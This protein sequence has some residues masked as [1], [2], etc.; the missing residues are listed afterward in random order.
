E[1]VTL[2]MTLLTAFNVLLYRYSGREDIVV[3][4][5]IAGRIRAEIEGL[6]GFFVNTLALRNDVSGNPT[7]RQLLARVREVCFQAYAHQE[8]PFEK[9]VQELRPERNRNQNPI[10]QVMFISQNAPMEIPKCPGLRVSLLKTDSL[11][12]KFDLTLAMREEKKGQLHGTLQYSTDLFDAAT[13]ERMS[14]HFE[15]LLEGIVADP[16]QRVSDFPLL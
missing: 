5:P 3:G 12:A 6:I 9:L 1:N 16:D 10:F 4:T 7:F 11:S 15:T 8:L 13:I 2:F 14:K